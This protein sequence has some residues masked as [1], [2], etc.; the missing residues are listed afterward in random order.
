MPAGTACPHPAHKS[1][2]H[3]SPSPQC[4]NARGSRPDLRAG[5]QSAHPAESPPQSDMPDA[6]AP[7]HPSPPSVQPSSVPPR[8][9][10][11]TTQPTTAQISIRASASPF[12]CTA[13]YVRAPPVALAIAIFILRKFLRNRV[14]NSLVQCVYNVAHVACRPSAV[15]LAAPHTNPGARQSHVPDGHRQ[16]HAGQLLWRRLR[17]PP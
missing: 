7:V 16:S 8:R 10:S 17:L 5:H 2:F 15:S 13:V 12:A 11:T 14:D 3:P 9:N 4:P 6:P 1:A